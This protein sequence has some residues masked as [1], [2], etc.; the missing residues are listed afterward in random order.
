MKLTTKTNGRQ[1]SDKGAGCG[2]DAGDRSCTPAKPSAKLDAGNS[3]RYEAR[4]RVLKALVYPTRLFIVDR[5]AAREHC[6]CEFTTMISAD[7][8]TISKHLAVLRHAGVIKDEKRGAWVYY[9]LCCPCILEFFGCIE[10]VL[11]RTAEKHLAA[12]EPRG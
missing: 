1:R 6:V 3:A 10:Q 7:L 8:S 9:S 5:L 4:A 2:C 12:V 11:K